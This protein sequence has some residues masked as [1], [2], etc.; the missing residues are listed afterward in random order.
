MDF[1]DKLYA[2]SLSAVQ[3]GVKTLM[4]AGRA[5]AA[6]RVVQGLLEGKQGTEADG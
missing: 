4:G 5:S 6:A 3:K 2:Q 1:A